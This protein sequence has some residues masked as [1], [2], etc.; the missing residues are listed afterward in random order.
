MTRGRLYRWAEEM[1]KEME[2]RVNLERE[3]A[4]AGAEASE[5][6]R[7]AKEHIIEVGRLCTSRIQLTRSA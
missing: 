7:S 3:R 4:A 2:A 1:R 6:L 5:K